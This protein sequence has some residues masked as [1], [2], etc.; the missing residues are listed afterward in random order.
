MPTRNF[1]V[2]LQGGTLL[3]G[4]REEDNTNNEAVDQQQQTSPDP[5][6][7]S[8][9]EESPAATSTN[10]ITEYY[11]LGV[12][13][14]NLPQEGSAI[15]KPKGIEGGQDKGGIGSEEFTVY[16]LENI[17]KVESEESDHPQFSVFVLEDN[18][19]DGQNHTNDAEWQGD[20]NYQII[21][22]ENSTTSNN[23]SPT[24]SPTSSSPTSSPQP[25]SPTPSPTTHL[26]QIHLTLKHY[27]VHLKQMEDLAHLN[28]LAH[29]HQKTSQNNEKDGQNLEKNRPIRWDPPPTYDEDG[30]EIFEAPRV[31]SNNNDDGSDAGK[32]HC[33]S[34]SGKFGQ[35]NGGIVIRYQYELTVN[36]D[37]FKMGKT[38]KSILPS[39]EEGIS[40]MLLPVFFHE[41]CLSVDTTNSGGGGGGTT[42]RDLME[43]DGKDKEEGNEKGIVL[44]SSVGGGGS[45]RG[46]RGVGGQQQDHRRLSKVVG[47]DS[48]PG[49]F[50]VEQGELFLY[51]PPWCLSL[52]YEHHFS[53][54]LPL[55][56]L[57]PYLR[58]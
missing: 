48:E 2:L 19:D 10:D 20:V 39:I 16:S 29:V 21:I 8:A 49:D 50:P 58:M 25:T 41:E 46:L 14:K 7:S 52:F 23:N 28:S 26:Q 5:M 36:D 13:E 54:P 1:D 43:G 55:V 40:D 6:S 32:I 33:K 12:N 15:R 53:F 4:S 37:L 22:P 18:H 57:H 44:A 38:L 9:A 30:N 17:D 11:L 35:R 42:E 31:P 51:I 34:T 27:A 56:S 45:S 3:R 24:T 47:L